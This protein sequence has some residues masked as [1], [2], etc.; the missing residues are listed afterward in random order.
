M[1]PLLVEKAA[2][3]LRPGWRQRQVRRK[4][5]WNLV[6]VLVAFGLAAF[7]WYA[8]FQAA[9]GL[10]VQLYPEHSVLKKEFWGRGISFRAFIPSFLMLMPLGIIAIVAGMISANCLVWLIPPARR[11]MEG[12]AA[13]DREMTFAGSNAGLLKWGGL[14]SAICAILSLI[15]LATLKHLR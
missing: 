4:S 7:F 5:P 2:D 15:G 13:G 1:D 12:E 10:H 8:L 6:C 14:L 11:A 9:W 3:K